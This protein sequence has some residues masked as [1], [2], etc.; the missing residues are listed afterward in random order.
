ME[1]LNAAMKS[2]EMLLQDSARDAGVIRTR[3]KTLMKFQR[4]MSLRS[5]ERKVKSATAPP[6]SIMEMVLPKTS[7]K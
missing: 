2:S 7:K 6:L 4:V 5:V 1:S 3:S